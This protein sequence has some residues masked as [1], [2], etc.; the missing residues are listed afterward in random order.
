VALHRANDRKD[1]RAAKQKILVV[2][3]GFIATA[4]AVVAVKLAPQ[5]SDYLVFAHG[6]QEQG[7]QL[8][9]Q[10]LWATPLL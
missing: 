7:H 6:S 8:M 9:L 5:S 4:A 3:D 1:F 2:I 10:Q